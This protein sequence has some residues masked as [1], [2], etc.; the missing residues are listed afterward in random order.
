MHNTPTITEGMVS[1]GKNKANALLCLSTTS[2][3]IEF[4]NKIPI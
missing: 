4:L 2:M 3:K 1:S